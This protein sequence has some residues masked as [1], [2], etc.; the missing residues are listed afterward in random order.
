MEIVYTMRI[1][2]LPKFESQ[3]NVW[4]P[5]D[6]DNV[7]NKMWNFASHTKGKDLS[8][9]LIVKNLLFS[10]EYYKRYQDNFYYV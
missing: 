7:N 4:N 10:A 5:D 3:D 9:K 6:Q 8:Q 1:K 2:K